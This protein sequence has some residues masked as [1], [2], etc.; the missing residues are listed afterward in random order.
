AT[1]QNGPYGI[2]RH[3]MAKPGQPAEQFFTTAQTGGRCVA[4]HVLSRDGIKMAVTYDGGDGMATVV[5]VATKTPQATQ[6]GWNFG[7]FTPDGS[8]FLANRQGTLTVMDVATQATV[9][10]MTASGYVTHPDLAADG[11]RLVYVQG[12]GGT[13]DWSFGGGKIFTRTFDP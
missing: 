8:K 13:S 4:C 6:R 9:A 2:F 3:D 10:T 5:D 12:P 1:A 7:A 11:T